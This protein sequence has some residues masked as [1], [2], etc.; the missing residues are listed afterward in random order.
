[1]TERT[2]TKKPSFLFLMNVDAFV[3]MYFVATI[4]HKWGHSIVAWLLGHKGNPF[5]VQFGGWLLLRINEGV[6]YAHLMAT[7]NET[8][9]AI[10]GIA[11]VATSLLIVLV[12]FWA[13]SYKRIGQHPV[14]F[15]FIYWLLVISMIPVLQYLM[16]TVFSSQGDVGYFVAGLGISAWWVFIP[17]TVI[18]L[19]CLWRIFT[20]EVIKGY[21]VIPIKDLWAKRVFL[22]FTVFAIFILVYSN[23]YNP[24]SDLGNPLLNKVLALIAIIA[25][26]IIFFICNPS[27]TW[28]KQQ[29]T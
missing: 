8:A 9:A 10:I 17:G 7:Q 15:T 24:L 11:G 23:N 18:T 2:L 1:M 25:A 5:D 14:W 4:I 26:P 22:F 29:L 16:L 12:C 13:L 3:I 27:R 21:S 20:I 28:V 19:Y 6:D